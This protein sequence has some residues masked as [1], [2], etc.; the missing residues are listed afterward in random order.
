MITFIERQSE[1]IKAINPF[2]KTLG[3]FAEKINT[4]SGFL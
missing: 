2:S 3:V 4:D 1:A